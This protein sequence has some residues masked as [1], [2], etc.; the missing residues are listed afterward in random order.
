MSPL[1]WDLAPPPPPD[2]LRALGV[3]SPLVARLLWNRGLRDAE[4]AHRFLHPEAQPLGDPW[5]MAGVADGVRGIRAAIASGQRIAI[6]GDYDADGVTATAVIVE[7]LRHL[8]AEPI[9]FVPHRTRDGYGLSPASVRALADQGAGLI[10]TVDCGIT[11]NAEIALAAELGLE[12][13]VT[14]HHHVP[15]SLPA[16]RAVM[17]PRQPGCAY[18]YLD[19]SGVGVAFVLA[20]ALLHEA[21]PVATADAAERALLDLVAIGTVADLVPLAGENRTLVARGLEV[22]RAG[23]RPGLDALIVAA[24][25][26]PSDLSAQ[27]IA[28]TLAPRLNAAGRMAEA[29]DAYTLLVTPDPVEARS[30]AESLTALNRERQAAVEAGVALAREQVESDSAAVIA[31]GDFPAGIAGLIAGKLAEEADRPCIVLEAGVTECRGSARGPEGFHLAVALQECADLLVKFGGHAQ[32]AGMTL[33]ASDLPAFVE[34]FQGLAGAARTPGSAATRRP[35]DGVLSLRAINWAFTED[36]RALEPYGMGNPA[37]VFRTERVV[38]REARPLG[39]RGVALRLSDGG[40]PLR[41]TRFGDGATLPPIGASAT[42]V[43]EVERQLWN[44]QIRIELR[45]RDLQPPQSRT[46]TS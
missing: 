13:V 11:A 45:L 23:G 21:L 16:A 27:R 26:E 41:A 42:A 10:I 24:G 19:L 1:D 6:H 3:A 20:R 28:F 22:L 31:V 35:I 34:R 37:P 40:L 43:Y 33:R 8:G 25:L 18:G 4:A 36:L 29:L 46:E 38:V 7:T 44:G 30:L 32:A 39:E 17:N 2:A 14:D 5:R 15:V 12:V 9:V